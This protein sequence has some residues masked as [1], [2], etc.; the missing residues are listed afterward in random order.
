M[1]TGPVRTERN[2]PVSTVILSRPQ[3]RNALDGPTG[4]AL[5]EAFTDFERDDSASVAV[6]W[7]EGG[8]FCSGA[9]LKAFG[10]DRADPLAADAAAGA[11]RFAAGAGR[12]GTF[13][14]PE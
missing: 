4:T 2:G 8:T 10:T 3:A 1:S 11:A 7:G 5:F 13:P 12:G 9:D 6:L 14:E